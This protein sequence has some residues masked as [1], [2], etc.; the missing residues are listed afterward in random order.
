MKLKNKKMIINQ[1]HLYFLV[2][3]LMLLLGLEAAINRVKLYQQARLA[4]QELS[5]TEQVG[6]VPEQYQVGP[7]PDPAP[8]C[9]LELT[10]ATPTPT[11][12]YDCY[13]KILRIYDA[14]WVEILDYSTVRPGDRVYFV[15][16]GDC[17][18]PQGITNAQFRVNY[19]AWQ[20]P[21][22]LI[23]GNYYYRYDVTTGSFRVGAMV[24]NPVFGWM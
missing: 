2:F 11:P 13:C 3:G 12:S 17:N 22:G 16:E 4:Y 10:V 15:V 23:G 21:T 9:Q 18:H 8:A 6:E 5:L 20:P 7:Y 24:Y 1:N 14:Y 19:G